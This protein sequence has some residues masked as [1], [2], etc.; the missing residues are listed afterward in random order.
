[1]LERIVLLRV[2]LDVLRLTG[3]SVLEFVV[4]FFDLRGDDG[5]GRGGDL[6]RSFGGGSS[7]RGEQR[8]TGEVRWEE[9]CKG[10]YDEK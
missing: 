4:C 10:A 1:L 6:E 7:R 8:G 9:G 3:G 2:N 5:D